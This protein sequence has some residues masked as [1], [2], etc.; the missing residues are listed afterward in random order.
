MPLHPIKPIQFGYIIFAFLMFLLQVVLVPREKIRKL[1][2]FSLIWGPAVDLFLV[3]ITRAL[4]LYQYHYLE[5]FEFL[6]AP[7][8][9][10]LAWSPAIILFIHFLPERKERYAVPLYIG[11]FSMVGVFV[12]AY[13]TEL[14]LIQNIHF[15]YGW[16]FPIWYLWFSAA[17]WHYRKLKAADPENI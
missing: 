7:I 15:H 5:P 10:S 14:G 1:F 12:G 3:W 6:G 17:Y 13:Y 2:W 9:N 8:L 16:R 11:V 4:Q